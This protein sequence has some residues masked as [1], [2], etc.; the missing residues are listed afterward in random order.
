MS[1]WAVV[2]VAAAAVVE[3]GCLVQ[4]TKVSD[5][6]PIFQQARLEAQRLAGRRGPAR[7]VNVLVYDP[8]DRELVRVS[9]P[10]WLVTKM[11][12][13]VDWHDANV[14][15]DDDTE[16]IVRRATR[17]VKL[18]DLAKAGLGTFVEVDEEDGEQVLVWLK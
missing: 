5:P 14:E 4:I 16:R 7:E 15:I 2:A 12:R 10:M 3:T 11:D 8:S 13:H 1:R 9:V 17:R 6:R 18:D